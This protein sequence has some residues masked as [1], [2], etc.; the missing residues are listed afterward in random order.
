MA[1]G[2]NM[3]EGV[4]F[5]MEEEG[6]Y[7]MWRNLFEKV[8]WLRESSDMNKENRR[9]KEQMNRNGEWGGTVK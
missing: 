2:R 9:G 4:H 6:A 7:P 1:H 5:A 8:S 3:Q